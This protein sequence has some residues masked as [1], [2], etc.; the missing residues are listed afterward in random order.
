M[1]SNKWVSSLQL[2]IVIINI[3][4][5]ASLLM[6]PRTVAET[7]KQDMWLSVLLASALMGTSFRI[8]AAL[9]AYF[10]AY[11]SIEYHCILLG[12][13]FGNILNCI[14]LALMLAITAQFVRVFRM[15]V[16]IFLLDL[17]PS[18]VIVLAL[19]L[20]ALYA[21]QHGLAPVIRVQ[22]FLFLFSYS[23]FIFLILLGL[24][25]IE[26]EHYTP[27]LANGV[28][29]VLQG[30]AACWMAYSGPEF[31]IGLVYPYVARRESVIRF[32]LAGIGAVAVLYV[33]ITGIT[34]GILGPEEIADFLIPTVMAYRS[35]EIPDTFIERIDGYLV[36]VWI[37]ICFT[38]LVN[39][40]YFT[41]FGI[42]RMMKLENSRSVIVLLL[43]VIC[44]L[45]N[46]P[47]DIQAVMASASWLNY[48]G[49]AW[50][51][52][53]LPL[54]WGIAWWRRRR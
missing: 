9:A 48:I 24:L 2:M 8:A 3:M 42:A 45:E 27:V 10:P 50:G 30:T 12:R 7:A 28:K 46:L 21:T 43:P 44:Y 17:T 36:I 13:T 23:I 47:P 39:W 51:L 53:V 20:L 38:A 40:L 6:L 14:M 11:T 4:V 19:L 31:I 15:A 54:L 22:Q 1:G 16:K 29:P 33:F 5:G 37:A 26:A 41:G 25:A 34:L 49:L 18:Q 32:G 35:V 52:G